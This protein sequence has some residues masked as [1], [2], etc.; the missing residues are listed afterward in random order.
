MIVT[1]SYPRGAAKGADYFS[2]ASQRSITDV[3]DGEHIERPEKIIATGIEA[4]VDYDDQGQICLSETTVRHMG[5]L[6]GLY[7][8]VQVDR[9]TDQ[10]EM[11]GEEN[12]ALHVEVLR[13]G[14][15][16]AELVAQVAA[17]TVVYVTPDGIEHATQDSAERALVLHQAPQVVTPNPQETPNAG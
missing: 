6:V 9:L 8:P 4:G 5:N 2:G 16:N 11:V 3:V 14:R 13:L 1:D 7:D 10:L 12:Q 17:P 15:L